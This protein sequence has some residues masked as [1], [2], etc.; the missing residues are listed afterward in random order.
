M[1]EENEI[2]EMDTAENSTSEPL[3]EMTPQPTKKKRVLS[4]QQREKLLANLKKGR[5]TALL[6]R[7]KKAYVK[8]QVRKEK[9][10]EIED[11]IIKNVMQKKEAQPQKAEIT[12]DY[13][14]EINTLKN[15]IEF[16]KK[17]TSKPKEEAV[18]KQEFVKKVEQQPTAPVEPIEHIISTFDKPFW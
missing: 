5:E 9:D 12:K 14:D 4:E 15:E 11:K 16:L 17:S 2:F 8:K 13:S 7:Q 1:K 18:P 10:Q 6:N 3:V